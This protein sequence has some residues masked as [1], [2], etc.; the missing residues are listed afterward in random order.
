MFESA[1]HLAAFK[2]SPDSYAIQN[3]GMCSRMGAPVPGNQGLFAVHEGRI[4]IFGSEG[5]VKAFKAAPAKFLPP[6]LT[7]PKMSAA[8]SAA[9]RQLLAKAAE[10]FGGSARVNGVTS[11]RTVASQ[12]QPGRAGGAPSTMTL[13]TTVVWPQQIRQ[14]MTMGSQAMSIV[15]STSDGFR[16]MGTELRS[17][18][19]AQREYL[20]T[21]VLRHPLWI[22]KDRTDP[23]LQ[24]WPEGRGKVGEIPTD[25]IGLIVRGERVRLS[26]EPATG[27][28]LRMTMVGR[29]PT[30]EFGEIAVTYS[31]FRD[32]GGG[33]VVAHKED[34]T[35]NGGA[36]DRTPALERVEV[37]PAID[38]AFFTRPVRR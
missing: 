18:D 7:P 38:A 31:D 36:A 11:L 28:V 26:I 5:C 29:G 19:E 34:R 16:T 24:V 13:T 20:R 17:L 9:A 21:E 1:D 12:S 37:N 6:D 22:V 3:R 4:Y 10:G 8:D 25:D 2:K 27:R 23:K 33:V 15:S 30:G 35:F 14:D 32:G